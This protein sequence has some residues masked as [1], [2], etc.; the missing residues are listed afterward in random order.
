MAEP[1][2]RTISASRR[3]LIT[4]PFDGLKDAVV[5]NQFLSSF[6]TLTIIPPIASVL[7]IFTFTS[8]PFYPHGTPQRGSARASLEGAVDLSGGVS[9]LVFAF[10]LVQLLT[11][12]LRTVLAIFEVAL[13][14]V[15]AGRPCYA[16]CAV[17]AAS[18]V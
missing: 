14:G 2:C 8:R 16:M 7:L 5:E 18:T 11:P 4:S 15:V 9:S 1:T 10:L 12:S 3:R 13:R 6:L 17:E